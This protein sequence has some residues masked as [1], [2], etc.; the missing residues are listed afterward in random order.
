MSS[1][2]SEVMVAI[3]REEK[4]WRQIKEA[5][6]FHSKRNYTPHLENDSEEDSF[7]TDRRLNDI[8]ERTV[9]NMNPRLYLDTPV[10]CAGQMN[11]QKAEMYK[12]VYR[13]SQQSLTKLHKTFD[14]SRK[15]P[16]AQSL[17]R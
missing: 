8:R 14:L 5:S 1:T 4:K 13:S 2:K 9:L 11:S 15:K 12:Q 17:N 7:C 16:H 6:R 3:T 10:S